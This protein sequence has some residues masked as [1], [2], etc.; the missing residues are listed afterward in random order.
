VCAEFF[1]SQLVVEATLVQ[2]QEIRGRDD[3]ETS[4]AA[5]YTMGVDTVLRG[6]VSGRFRVRP[7]NDSGR[8][9]FDGTPGTKYLL[10]LNYLPHEKSWQF[11]GCGNSAPVTDA[12][13]A[14]A[15]ID[16]IKTAQNGMIQGMVSQD[17]L[18]TPISGVHVEAAGDAGDFAT[19]TNPKGEF[20]L[21][22]PAGRYA[23][24]VVSSGMSFKKADLSYEDPSEIVIE[25]GGCAQVQLT[26]IG[27][28]Q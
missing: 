5:V 14:L 25:P 12:A 10:F 22:V 1:A 17:A 15:Q 28:S 23:V 27:N 18:T 13:A 8:A 16:A 26:G 4:S 3:S 19:N 21:H 7:G 20:R 24:H 2:A 9:A 6:K 11:D